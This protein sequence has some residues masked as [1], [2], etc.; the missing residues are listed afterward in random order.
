MPTCAGASAPQYSGV[1]AKGWK[2]VKVL[3]G[4]TGPRGMIQDSA[5]NLLVVQS[6][7]GISVHGVGADGCTTSSKLL[8]SQNN[9][10]HGIQL[11]ADGATLYAS[12]MT[13]VYKWTYN[14]NTT[15]VGMSTEIIT[16]LYNGGQQL[17]RAFFVLIW[18]FR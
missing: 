4:L 9:L 1:V 13:V 5:G 3:G 8:I 2:A 14:A 15:S 18:L 11:S 16:G 12:S 10:N 17:L 6:G 7:K